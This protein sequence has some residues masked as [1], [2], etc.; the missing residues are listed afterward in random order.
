MRI[1]QNTACILLLLALILEL[2]H[3]ASRESY[4]VPSVRPFHPGQGCRL[5][6]LPSPGNHAPYCLW[7]FLCSSS[8]SLW[9][10]CH[11]TKMEATS[12]QRKK[13]V[14]RA[15]LMSSRTCHI[16]CGCGARVSAIVDFKNLLGISRPPPLPPKKKEKYRFVICVFFV[17]FFQNRHIISITIP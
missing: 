11:D 8:A 9:N 3:H 17:A 6:I 14:Q 15:P 13:N 1:Q 5:T 16:H 10:Q 7:P 2:G 4:Y 12:K